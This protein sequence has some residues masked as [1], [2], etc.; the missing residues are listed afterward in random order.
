LKVD[1]FSGVERST[2][3]ALLFAEVL[4]AGVLTQG[5]TPFAGPG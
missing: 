5:W 4:A 2:V 3:A 1:D